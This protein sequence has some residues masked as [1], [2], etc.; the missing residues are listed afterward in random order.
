MRAAIH[1]SRATP[2]AT[3]TPRTIWE[4][5]AAEHQKPERPV[6]AAP[7]VL[8]ATV[9]NGPLVQATTTQAAAVVALVA[10]DDSAPVAVQQSEVKLPGGVK[11]PAPK[12][13]TQAKPTK[14]VKPAAALGQAPAVRGK[15]WPQP[16]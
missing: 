15:A 14:P 3:A 12:K 4:Q 13:V 1:P 7:P 2:E 11:K 16:C 5:G 6:Q 10:S 9:P 8:V